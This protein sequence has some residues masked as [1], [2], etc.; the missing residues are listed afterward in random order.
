LP[1]LG[2]YCYVLPR[3]SDGG[4]TITGEANKT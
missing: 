4:T 3:E 1:E 2:G